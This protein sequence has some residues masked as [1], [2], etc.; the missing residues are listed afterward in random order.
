MPDTIEIIENQI[1][2]ILSEVQAYTPLKTAYEEINVVEVEPE[3]LPAINLLW[4]WMDQEDWET[5]STENDWQWIIRIYWDAT[6]RAKA[7]QEM[8]MALPPTLDAL[9]QNRTLNDNCAWHNI[10]DGG[11]P[12]IFTQSGLLRKEILLTARTTEY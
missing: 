3:K 4:T 12:V 5:Q 1:V 9:R 7:Q 8:K 6:H 10:E 2:S 11:I